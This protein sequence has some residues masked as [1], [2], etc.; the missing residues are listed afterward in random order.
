MRYTQWCGA[1]FA[2]LMLTAMGFG[3]SGAAPLWF[4][5]ATAWADDAAAPTTS[6]TP[7]AFF[8]EPRYE[9]APIMEGADIEHEFIVENRGKAPLAIHKVQPD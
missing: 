2:L 1:I 3:G 5:T 9:F 6:G 8:V 7:Q 4:A